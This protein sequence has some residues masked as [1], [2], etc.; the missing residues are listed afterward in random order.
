MYP[1]S[2]PKFRLNENFVTVTAVSEP[3]DEFEI[4]GLSIDDRYLPFDLADAMEATVS[5]S[6]PIVDDL[7]D[8]GPALA[9]EFE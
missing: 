5:A 2:A 7:F 6:R 9:E 3:G 4:D 1:V 8:V